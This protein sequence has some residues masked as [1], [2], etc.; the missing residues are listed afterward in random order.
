MEN[1]FL[2]WLQRWE[3]ELEPLDL[4]TVIGDPSRTAIVS[5][6]LLRG[7]TSEGPLAS[8]RAAGILPAVADLF[9]RA[10]ARG[11]RH[12][13]LFQDTH[14]PDAVEFDAFPP[15][16]I[17]GSKES[18]TVP[19]L[20]ELP[21]SDLYTI[22]TK[23]SISS[24]SGTAFKQWLDAHPKVNTFIV[25]GVCTDICI[26]QV[27]VALRIRANVQGRSDVRVIIPADSVQT[28]DLPVEAARELG[29]MPHDGDLTHSMALYHMA[30]NC[31]EV[32][33]RLA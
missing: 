24:T 33:A 8:E 1:E 9:Q 7:F 14:E 31:I 29:A 2:E 26:Y 19:E 11:V 25:V 18:E 13:L 27:A 32:T 5:E 20:A 17:A 12:F 10:Y 15:H 16:C 21:F 4:E 3:E 23:N 22:F 28:Y 30:L 6:D